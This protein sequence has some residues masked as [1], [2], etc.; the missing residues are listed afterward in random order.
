[1]VSLTNY[2]IFPIY[3]LRLREKEFILTICNFASQTSKT[4]LNTCGLNASAGPAR[5]KSF[6]LEIYGFLK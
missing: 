3:K 1:M 4:T 2:L 6:V 5:D